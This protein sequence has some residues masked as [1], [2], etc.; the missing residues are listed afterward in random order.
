VFTRIL[1]MFQAA[2]PIPEPRLPRRA[3][4]FFD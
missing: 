4:S 3:T 2:S 1:G